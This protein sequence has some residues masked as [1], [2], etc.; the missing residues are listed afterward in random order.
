MIITI[1]TRE[2]PD[3]LRPNEDQ[4][5][6]LRAQSA[7]SASQGSS[8]DLQTENLD[9]DTN[10]FHLAYQILSSWSSCL[11]QFR[12][13]NSQRSSPMNSTGFIPASLNRSRDEKSANLFFRL[14]LFSPQQVSCPHKWKLELNSIKMHR[15]VND[16]RQFGWSGASKDKVFVFCFPSTSILLSNPGLHS[17]LFQFL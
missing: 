16:D 9:K 14:R 13:S 17:Y 8:R 6:G 4:T 7:L 10:T 2:R 15:E 5:G 3:S 12:N 11:W 1:M